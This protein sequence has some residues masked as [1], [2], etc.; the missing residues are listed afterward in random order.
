MNTFWPTWQENKVVATLLAIVLIMLGIFLGLK[1]WNAVAEHEAIGR[2]PR[3][4]DTI[5]MDGEGKISGKPTLAR[6][7]AG[8]YTEASDV[9]NAQNQNTQKMNSILAGIKALGVKEEDIQTSNYNIYPKFDYTN[10]KQNLMGYTVS[11]SLTIKVRDLAKVGDV[12]AKA[13]ELGANQ[14][15]GVNF[16]IDDPA[17]LKQDARK[18]AMD[19]ARNKAKE[20]ADALGVKIVR[21]VSF[22]ESSGGYAPAPWLSSAKAMDTSGREMIAPEIATGSL[23]V[24]S[25][26]SVTFEIQ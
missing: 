24:T 1:A 10:G 6:V 19:N 12:L 8:V 7:E 22:S 3:V 20:L 25:N 9:K 23:D 15:N 4:R 17:S 26:V 18:K 13:G 2:V 11:Q 5:T 14:V 16:S 21:V